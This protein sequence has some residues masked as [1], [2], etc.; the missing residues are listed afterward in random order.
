MGRGHGWRRGRKV[1][2]R[3]E[4]DPSD[5]L[6]MAAAITAFL[7][8]MGARN[9]SPVTSENRE[10]SLRRF[11]AWCELRAIGR[12]SEV[13]RP[14]LERYQRHL[15][16]RRKSDGRPLSFRSQRNELVSLR[17]FFKWLVR[18]NLVLS[19]PASD[20]D[21]PRVELRLP[22]VLT[23]AEAERVMRAP[24]LETPTGLR[25][26]A[27]L[28]TLYSTGMRRMELSGL[29]TYDL[30]AERGTVLIRQGKGKKDRWIP[31]GDRAVFW[32]D[33]YLIEARSV[34][35]FDPTEDTVF[36]TDSGLPFELGTLTH[37]VGEYVRSAGAGKPGACHL[38]RHTMATQMLE[39]GA[40][41]RFIQ[42]MLGHSSL[43]TTQIY[44]QVSIRKLK[45]V[46]TAT[47]PARLEREAGSRTSA[48]GVAA[49][50][51]PAEPPCT[52][53]DFLAALVEEAAEE[54]DGDEERSPE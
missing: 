12:P 31:I 24:N 48:P 52:A 16:H 15:F 8:W 37:L 33:R 23:E 3:V 9:Y 35:L 53:Q 43:A 5:P 32:I 41:I 22:P 7:E 54:D 29:K 18:Q 46:H 20:L 51:V 11:T 2:R 13:T 4:G 6:G 50:G 10:V 30:D 40:D 36:L 26:R 14:V 1:A 38:F 21:L 17:A 25:D 39:N 27:L 34:L 19:N 44:T 42:M 49:S 28:E 47:H 45:E